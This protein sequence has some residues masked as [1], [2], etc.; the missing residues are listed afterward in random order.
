M[1]LRQNYSDMLQ[2]HIDLSKDVK[3]SRSISNWFVGHLKFLLSYQQPIAI[4]GGSN[5]LR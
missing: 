1:N 3:N 2:F 4:A 5:V